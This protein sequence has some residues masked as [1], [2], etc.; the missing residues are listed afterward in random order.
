MGVRKNAKFLSATEKERFVKACVKMKADIVNPL[1]PAAAQ[2]SKWDEYVGI[3]YMIQ[4]ATAPGHVS[5]NYGHSSFSFLS[6][7]RYLLYQFEKDLQSYV[8]VDGTPDLMLPYWD[9]TDPAPLMT[10][11]F[12]GPSGNTAAGHHQVV[13]SG[14]FAVD[15][16]GSGSNPTLL[17]AWWPPAL[18]GWRLPSMF[19]SYFTGGLRR[20]IGSLSALPTASDINITLNK[21]NYSEFQPVL[22]RGDRFNPDPA[23]VTS[24]EMHGSIHGWIGGS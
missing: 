23:Q 22:E 7:H 11:T 2:Y 21:T 9:W 1:A 17:P 15:K 20:H 19:P 8:H 13:E 10:D 24:T 4:D 18:P 16:P 3:H 5:V 12:L 6:W 14:Y